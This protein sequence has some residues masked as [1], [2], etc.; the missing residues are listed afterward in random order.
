VTPRRPSPLLLAGLLAA[1]AAATG[2]SAPDAAAADRGPQG[3]SVLSVEPND[4]AIDGW[5]GWL[6][7]SRRADDGTFGLVARTPEGV[8]VRLPVPAQAAPI[9][10]S[11]GPGPD[12]GPLVVY[13]RCER[14]AASPPTGCDVHRIDPRTGVDAPV[15]SASLP[16]V[17]ER[18][19]SVWGDRIAFS[20]S[21][22]RLAARRSGVAVSTLDATAPPKRLIHGPRKERVGNRVRA[23]R[24]YTPDGI[25][26]HGT[27][28]A[29]VWHAGGVFDRW[30]LVVRR[31]ATTPKVLLTATSTRT[32]LRRLGRPVLSAGDVTVPRLRTGTR[33]RSEI[34]RTTLGGTRAWS[35][36]SG[37]TGAQ[38]TRYGSALTAVAAPTPT[39]L[40][41][42]RR[43]AS[44]G[45]WSC[46]N[47]AVA[48]ARGCEILQVDPAA[49][50]WRAVRPQSE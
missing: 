21:V 14:P 44:D 43:L 39:S 38:T 22:G 42:V 2:A 47:A 23:V 33:S 19:P 16:G 30:R 6:V 1:A 4:T 15:P 9:D 50:P 45:R 32:T 18:S 20:R 31:G 49:Q 28:L 37:F 17:D 29:F 7:W 40:V 48:A 12:G 34:Y 41:L 36:A 11:I 10:A 8:G 24:T 26:L 25:D 46:K 13:A 5:G 3:A 35:L 27:D